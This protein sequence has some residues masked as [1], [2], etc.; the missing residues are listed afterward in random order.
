[1]RSVSRD[2]GAGGTGGVADAGGP[3]G[4]PCA[5]GLTCCK[6]ADG[7]PVCVESGLM[8]TCATLVGGT[9]RCWGGNLA[10]QLGDG[11]QVSSSV[12]VEPQGL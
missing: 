5:G 9:F 10:G 1:M 8:H 4:C 3:D 12:P 7:G 11:S 2:G 6:S